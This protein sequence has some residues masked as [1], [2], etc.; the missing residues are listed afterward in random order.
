[1]NPEE[2]RLYLASR[3]RR[4]VVRGWEQA[5]KQLVNEIENYLKEVA[6]RG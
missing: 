6:R 3:V 5:A 2:F 4:T 1:M